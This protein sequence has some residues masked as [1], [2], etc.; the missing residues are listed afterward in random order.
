MN[1]TPTLDKMLVKLKENTAPSRAVELTL[2]TGSD[3]VEVDVSAVN[4]LYEVTVSKKPQKYT[5]QDPA[6]FQ[7]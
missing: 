1:E 4:S 2:V 6:L 7:P 3:G 5:L